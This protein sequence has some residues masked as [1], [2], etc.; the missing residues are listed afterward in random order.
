MAAPAAAAARETAVSDENRLHP[1]VAAARFVAAQANG[2]N[3]L[4]DAHFRRD[5]GY[6][7]GCAAVLTRWPCSTASIARASLAESSA[8]RHSSKVEIGVA[9]DVGVDG[10]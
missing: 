8:D 4:L 2:A 10:P 7:G 3:R 6:C 5:D 1:A 9:R